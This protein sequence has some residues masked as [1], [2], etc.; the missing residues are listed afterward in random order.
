MRLRGATHHNQLPVL[1]KQFDFFATGLVAEGEFTRCAKAE[2]GDV[3]RVAQYRF[4]IAVPPHAFTAVVVEIEQAGV[5]TAAAGALDGGFQRAQGVVPRSGV[6]VAAGI[7][8]IEGAVAIPGEF[9]RGSNGLAKY[10]E[11]VVL[12]GNVLEQ[13]LQITVCRVRR[14]NAAVI[15]QRAIMR[16]QIGGRV[17]RRR[18]EVGGW[19]G[20]VGKGKA[21]AGWALACR[22]GSG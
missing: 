3:G 6:V 8:V 2:R 16:Q 11:A 21:E 9:A 12:P 17:R 20:S 5:V 4:I 7:A 15:V 14:Q 22:P 1:Q 18:E 19:H 13:T 10:P